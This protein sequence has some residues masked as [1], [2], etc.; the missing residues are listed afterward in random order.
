MKACLILCPGWSLNALIDRPDFYLRAMRGI[1]VISV[2]KVFEVLR[3]H[4]SIALDDY[5]PAALSPKAA[6]VVFTTA[7]AWLRHYDIDFGWRG[8]VPIHRSMNDVG[9]GLSLPYALGLALTS[10]EATSFADCRAAPR[11][12]PSP[13]RLIGVLGADG[14][15]ADPA[16]GDYYARGITQP[17]KKK[18]TIREATDDWIRAVALPMAERRRVELFNLSPSSAF[19]SLSHLALEEFLE[20]GA[21][22]EDDAAALEHLTAEACHRI[23]EAALTEHQGAA[24]E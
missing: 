14:G 6:N 4:W 20:R 5:G 15:V 9:I 24:R 19:E 17:E 7:E 11:P 18:P 22:A 8:V 13:F 2:S 12:L 10:H 21:P 16:T 23:G 3:A 1:H